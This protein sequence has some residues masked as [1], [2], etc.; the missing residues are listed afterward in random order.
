MENTLGLWISSCTNVLQYLVCKLAGYQ[1]L[2]ERTDGEE[3]GCREFAYRGMHER[4]AFHDLRAL[5]ENLGMH[6]LKSIPLHKAI[7]DLKKKSKEYSGHY[8][9]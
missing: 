3:L 7:L 5:L 4:R 9:G 1:S 6:D 8:V 2:A